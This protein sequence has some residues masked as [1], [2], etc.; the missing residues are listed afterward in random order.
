MKEIDLI[1]RFHDESYAELEEHGGVLELFGKRSHSEML[2]RG[3][4]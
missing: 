1:L 3:I 2:P 4:H